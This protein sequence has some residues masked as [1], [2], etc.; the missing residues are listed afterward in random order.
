MYSVSSF[1]LLLPLG[2]LIRVDI[3]DETEKSEGNDGDDHVLPLGLPMQEDGDHDYPI[4][5]QEGFYQMN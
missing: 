2:N 4:A 3:D 5:D 1:V